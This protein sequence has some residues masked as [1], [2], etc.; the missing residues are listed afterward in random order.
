MSKS[1]FLEEAI[2]KFSD[3]FKLEMLE[4]LLCFL[5]ILI[6][7]PIVGAGKNVQSSDFCSFLFGVRS[8]QEFSNPDVP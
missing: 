2:W 3:L 6:E 1:G 7:L 8:M 5:V 4:F